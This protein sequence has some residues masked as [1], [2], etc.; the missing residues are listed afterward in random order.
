MGLS[1]LHKLRWLALKDFFPEASI[2]LTA[3]GRTRRDTA[4]LTRII[5]HDGDIA[6]LYVIHLG[7]RVCTLGGF[8]F[9]LKAEASAPENGERR[10]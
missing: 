9:L 6:G 1:I 5:L 2:F 10:A 4:Q 7:T 3:N 8:R